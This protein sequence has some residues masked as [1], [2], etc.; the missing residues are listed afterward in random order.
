ML[1]LQAL[2]SH[3]FTETR[4]VYSIDTSEQLYNRYT[5]DY[6]FPRGKGKKITLG[7]QHLDKVYVDTGENSDDI[8]RLM[9]FV[10]D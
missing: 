3:A 8:F 1:P 6:S 10:T 7:Y 9:Y 4:Y 5:V 2:E